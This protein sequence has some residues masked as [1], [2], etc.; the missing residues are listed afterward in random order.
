MDICHQGEIEKSA[1]AKKKKL[2]II[3][4]LFGMPATVVSVFNLA[5]TRE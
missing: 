5:Q 4:F 2:S 1:A 3:S